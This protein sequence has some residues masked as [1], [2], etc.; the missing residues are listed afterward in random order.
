MVDT[1]AA[2]YIF[3]GGP[4]SPIYPQSSMTDSDFLKEYINQLVHKIRKSENC[5]HAILKKSQN[6]ENAFLT[7]PWQ[8]NFLESTKRFVDTVIEKLK[9]V[10]AS[11]EG[12]DLMFFTSNEI[13]V[14]HIC[15][16]YLPYKTSAVHFVTNENNQIHTDIIQH[17]FILPSSTSQSFFGAIVNLESFEADINDIK[18]ATSEGLKNFFTEILL[19]CESALSQKEVIRSVEEIAQ[20]I[21]PNLSEDIGK[22]RIKQAMAKSVE[23]TGSIDIDVVAEHLFGDNPTHFDAFTKEVESSVSDQQ[24]PIQSKKL[25]HNLEKIRILT[26]NGISISLPQRIANDGGSFIVVNN[27]D[28]SISITINNIM[29]IK[30]Q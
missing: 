16:A 17:R 11:I 7:Y 2:L 27:A 10:S 5:K 18:V 8:N 25:I 9:V 12:Y 14:D 13:N 19:D 4:L 1:I 23:S 21:Q 20:R 15:I 6:N 28:G 24:L 26:D 3:D 22:R 29:K 30:T